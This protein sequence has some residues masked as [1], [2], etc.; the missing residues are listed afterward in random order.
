VFENRALM[1]IYLP[2]WEEEEQD[3]ENCTV[4]RFMISTYFLPNISFTKSSK[5]RCAGCAECAKC[6]RV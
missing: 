1:G 3:K 6:K 4:R 5:M 2:K